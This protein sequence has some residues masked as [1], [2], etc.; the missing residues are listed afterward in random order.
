MKPSYTQLESELYQTRAELDQTRAELDQTRAELDQTRAELAQTKDL[1]KRALEEIGKLCE[2]V[3]KLKDQINRNSKNS[4][5]PPSS[6]Q[7]GNTDPNSPKKER[8][9]RK[10]MARTPFPQERVDHS[11][12]CLQE[13]CP[14]CGS[15]TIHLNGQLPEILQ[16]AELPDVKATVTEYQLLKYGCG[17]CG[18]NSVAPLP[19]GVPDSAFG[20]KLMGLLVTLTGVFHLAKR[21]AVQLIRELYDVDM[22]VGSVSNIEERVSEALEPIYQRIH[23]FIIDSKFCKH[24]DETGWRDQGKRHYVWLA[25][26]EQAAF[27]MIDRHR[28]TE[29]FLKLFT[30]NPD[31]ASVVTDRYAVYSMFKIHQ[32]CLSHLIRDFHGYAER[33]GLDKE[34]GEALENELKTACHIHKNYRE[35]EITLDERNR[36]IGHCKREVEYH[37][38]DG[39]ANGS[40]ELFK[41]SETLLDDFE[42]LW[43]FTKIPGMEPTN[44]LAERDLRKLVIWRRKSYGTRS[45]RGKKFVERMTTVAQT[46]KRR[47]KNILGFIQ[48]VIVGFYSKATAPFIFEAMGF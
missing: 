31:H 42:K 25:C 35:G 6:D 38:E 13:N 27:Y 29:A 41:L 1:L 18:K 7:K 14:H 47:S 46:L 15:S 4:S 16:Q 9:K 23:S 22:G 30:E 3:T 37:L 34:I 43:T 20:P 5:K 17:T 12:Q 28:S 39:M 11:V 45:D 2:E 32:Y 10:G 36:R 19:C 26:N 8:L 48:D 21:E 33:D 24:F 44:N 40:N